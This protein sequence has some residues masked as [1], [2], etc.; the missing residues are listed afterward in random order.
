MVRVV[1]SPL[2][3][4]G[5]SLDAL[6]DDELKEA[7]RSIPYQTLENELAIREEVMRRFNR[8]YAD[9]REYLK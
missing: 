4:R 1:Y 7:A 3:Y 9:L 6:T 2:K 5:K 8:G